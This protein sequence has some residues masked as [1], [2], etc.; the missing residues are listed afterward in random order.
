MGCCCS[1][2]LDVYGPLS[3]EDARCFFSQ[4]L[5]AIEHLH[6]R[7]ICHMDLSL[8][9]VLVCEAPKASSPGAVV[10]PAVSPC[11]GSAE[12]AAALVAP[13]EYVSA[14]HADKVLKV[15]D[16]GVARHLC[17][18]NR[19]VRTARGY[20][21]H[22]SGL[23]GRKPGKLR[24]MA[25]EILRGDD[26][27]GQQSDVFN[28]VRKKCDRYC[29]VDCLLTSLLCRVSCCFQCWWGIRP[30]RRRIVMMFATP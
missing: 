10:A 27:E 29:M 3:D 8:E 2:Y 1:D 14:I 13:S 25:P 6:E 16:F 30:L 20:R 9:N 26:F 21:D 18:A 28:V 11:V 24:Y 23:P 17:L 15:C 5:A 7:G 19:P 22:F 12:A 4:V